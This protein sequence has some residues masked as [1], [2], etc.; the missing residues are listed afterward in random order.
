[1]WKRILIAVVGLVVVI[2]ALG[3]VKAAQI[4]AMIEAGENFRPPPA[5]I[6]TAEVLSQVWAPSLHATGT[7][8][9]SQAVVVSSE[10]PGLVRKLS[11]ESGQ[12]VKAGQVLVRLDTSI[13]QT[14][15]KSAQATAKL[16]E[17][18]LGRS[19][20]LSKARVNAPAELD[21]AEAEAAGA[22]AQVDN[23]QAQIDKKLI[24]AP[25][26]GRLGIRQVELGQILSSGS[27][28]AAL[29][30]LT[31]VYTD[32]YLP[33]ADLTRIETGQKVV[34]VTDGP[35][36]RIWTG[37]IETIE[38]SIQVATRTV[39]VRAVFENPDGALR[40]GMFVEV[41][42]K[43]PDAAA[44]PVIPATA[45]V[46]APY[47]DSVYVVEAAKPAADGKAPDPG[48]KVARQIFVKLGNRKGDFVVVESGL[49]PGQTVVS[50]GAFKLRNGSGVV[51]DN[52]TELDP[53]LAP[54]PKDS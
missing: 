16:A 44:M 9:A 24:R 52:S 28:V 50:A 10:V 26:S 2:G 42:V 41:R 43:L 5:S 7:I 48:A 39:R 30:N 12:T 31:R 36:D 38:S 54:K 3:G 19:R 14:Q 8:V 32:F 33:Q 15:L 51:V 34:I 40:S 27:P 18:S 1:M 53:S 21:R 25:F 4:G 11:F 6:S 17:I 37:Q 47:G 13:E 29:Q 45:V 46:F 20:G 35:L 49:K 23:I 22:A